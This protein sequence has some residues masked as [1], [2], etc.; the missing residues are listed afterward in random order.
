MTTCSFFPT[1]AKVWNTLPPPVRDATSIYSFK[2]LAFGIKQRTS[3]YNNACSGKKGNW[4]TRLRLQLSPLNQHRFRYNLVS[5]PYCDYCR[6]TPEST[7]HFFFDCPK[8]ANSPSTY[9][10]SI[11]R[12]RS[13][14]FK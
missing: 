13:Q 10:S 12:H 14:C 9:S 4:I 2:R 3:K 1:T 6:N 11:I 8:Y 5:V 7:E